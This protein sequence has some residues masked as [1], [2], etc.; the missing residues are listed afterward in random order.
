MEHQRVSRDV[1]VVRLQLDQ[2]LPYHPGQYVSVEIPQC[3]RR[4]RYLSPAMPADPD[5]YIEFHVR[6]VAGGL[7]SPAVV[8]DLARGSVADVE[9]ARCPAR[10][11]RRR[12]RA[13]GGRQHRPGT[14]ASPD[15]GPDAVRDEP[16]GPPVLRRALSVR[17]LRPAHAV[18]DRQLQP[19]LS[20]SPV[21][22]FATDPPWAADYPDPEP[23]Q[24]LHLR[25]TGRLPEVVTGYGGWGDR[26]ILLCGRPE[27]VRNEVRAGRSGGRRTASSTT[28]W[29]PDGQPIVS[30]TLFTNR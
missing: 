11:P 15:H 21:S 4:W 18:G 8:R 6:A 30:L 16:A 3:P 23:P 2:P 9:P 22:E 26:Q 19:W 29:F 7:V 14:V 25:Q 24:G 28:H 13:D 27:M 17:A 1:A 12:R 5:G 20:V 10:G